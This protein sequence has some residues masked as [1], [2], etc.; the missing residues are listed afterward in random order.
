MMSNLSVSMP[1]ALKQWVEQ[2]LSQGRY[3]SAADYVRD[4]VRRDQENAEE[5]VRWLKA[6]IDEGLASGMIDA[7]PEDVIED[8]IAA[9]PARNG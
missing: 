3:A 2:R 7:E 6:M 1:P 4:L 9:Y 8:I 5:D